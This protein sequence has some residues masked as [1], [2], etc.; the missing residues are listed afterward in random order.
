M[1]P[2]TRA[3]SALLLPVLLAVASAVTAQ[4]SAPKFLKATPT[5]PKSVQAGKPFTISVAVTIDSPYHIQGNPS[6]EGYIA[7]ELEVG[8][9]KGFKMDKVTYP[10]PTETTMGGEKLPVYAGKLNIKADVTPD[11]AVKPGKYSLPITVKYQGC[12][13]QKCFPPATLTTKAI[14]TVTS[15][16]K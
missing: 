6:K 12:D 3:L 1:K 14:V 7:T 10:K 2:I 11:K 13:D 15:G 5:A 9:L 16:V 4:F 8:H